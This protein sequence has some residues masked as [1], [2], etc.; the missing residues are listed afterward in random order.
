MP[1]LVYSQVN[2][3]DVDTTQE[4]HAYDECRYVLVSGPIASSAPRAV[5]PRAY[6]LLDTEE[7]YGGYEWLRL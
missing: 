4:D 1:A 5:R 7:S 6:S 2:P 3:E